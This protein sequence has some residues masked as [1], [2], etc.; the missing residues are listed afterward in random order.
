RN[1][2]VAPRRRAIAVAAGD[3]NLVS[4]RVH[5]LR[6][7]E[8]VTLLHAAA[9]SIAGIRSRDRST[10]EADAGADRGA[11]AAA[12]ESARRRA[13]CGAYRCAPYAGVIGGLLSARAAH[14]ETRVLAARRVVG[15]EC[16]EVL[17]ASRQ[18]Q[19]ART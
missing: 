12:D 15:A 19:H 2:C 11:L 14:L 13:D 18:N 9:R 7:A 1:R 6:V 17:A 4:L 8:V 3:R 10:G 5:A 16:V